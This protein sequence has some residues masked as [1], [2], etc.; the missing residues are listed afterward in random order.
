MDHLK[1]FLVS[2]QTVWFTAAILFSEKINKS[3]RWFLTNLEIIFFFMEEIKLVFF[4]FFF[5]F[6]FIFYHI[7]L[8]SFLKFDFIGIVLLQILT[9]ILF[10]NDLLF[11]LLV[12][13]RF[14]ATS[15]AG[16]DRFWLE[17]LNQF[18]FLQPI[19]FLI[20][21]S[22]SAAPLIKDHFEFALDTDLTY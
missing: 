10:L 14:C 12:G 16:L 9:S 7:L 15:T 11:V 5:K 19:L 6:Q 1:S 18:F 13:C 2:M 8:I 20:S 21:L 3:R 4:F 22:V 17:E